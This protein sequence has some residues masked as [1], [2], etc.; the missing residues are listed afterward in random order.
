[1]PTWCAST[2]RR[3]SACICGDVM[4]QWHS[5]SCFCHKKRRV[6]DEQDAAF[7]I[8]VM[9]CSD[10]DSSGLDSPNSSWSIARLKENLRKKK[11]RPSKRGHSDYL[12]VH[13]LLLLSVFVA[14]F[15]L[16]VVSLG[17]H[18]SLVC[19]PKQ[20]KLLQVF[21]MASFFGLCLWNLTFLSD[22]SRSTD[23][24]RSTFGCRFQSS[25][26]LF[27]CSFPFF[28]CKLSVI[29]RIATLLNADTLHRRAGFGKGQEKD[30]QC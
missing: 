30:S 3:A 19:N 10:C 4:H 25:S 22:L 16:P 23:A 29:A 13:S 12:T 14:R 1:M 9:D 11:T 27:H 20:S 28:F 8:S 6:S 15:W 18:S 21:S 26:F 24:N 5:S 7:L 17:S 2:R